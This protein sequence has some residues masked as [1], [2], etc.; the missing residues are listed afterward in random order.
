MTASSHRLCL[1]W[2][3][4]GTGQVSPCFAR[5][6]GVDV[7][8]PVSEGK[9]QV[10]G[11]Q[12]PSVLCL[13]PSHSSSDLNHMILQ[14]MVSLLN[15]TRSRPFWVVSS[16][17]ARATGANQ[18]TEISVSVKEKKKMKQT[19]L[20]LFKLW[21]WSNT[22]TGCPTGFLFQSLETAK[23]QLDMV[24]IN[25]QQGHCVKWSPEVLANLSNYVVHNLFQAFT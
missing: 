16:E 21:E 23:T 9:R 1:M 14:V 19:K 13:S 6:G 11:V 24:M 3:I 7:P 18:R 17:R 25:L 5:N 15:L 8:S 20:H 12:G 22:G 2:Y 4:A 10:S